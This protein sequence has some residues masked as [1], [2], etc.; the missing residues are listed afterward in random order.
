[1]SYPNNLASRPTTTL[2]YRRCGYHSEYLILRRLKILSSTLVCRV[3]IFRFEQPIRLGERAYPTPLQRFGVRLHAAGLTI[4]ETVAILE[5]LGVD[6]SPSAVGIW[7]HTLSE[8]QIDPP[9]A[10]LSRSQS[11]RNKLRLTAKKGGYSLHRHRIKAT[12]RTR[13]V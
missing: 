9:T 6:H 1:M 8:T 3:Q 10:S 2:C 7:V 4:R 5:L 12:A 13:P 11:M